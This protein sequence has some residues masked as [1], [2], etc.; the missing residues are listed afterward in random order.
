[1]IRN[2][3]ITQTNDSSLRERKRMRSSHSYLKNESCRLESHK[4]DRI[5]PKFPKIGR[6]WVNYFKISDFS[7]W[8]N[9]S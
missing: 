9:D 3:P 8:M 1:M 4:M 6:G 5:F 7:S 2:L